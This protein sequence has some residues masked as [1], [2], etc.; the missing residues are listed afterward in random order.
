MKF[1]F[2]VIIFNILIIFFLS[3]VAVLP[4]ALLGRDFAFTFWRS[5]WPLAGVLLIALIVLNVFFLSNR[6]LFRLL[7]REDWP[8]L[9]DYLEHVVLGKRQYSSRK[10][11]LLL[12][13]YLV[14]SDSP[15]VLRL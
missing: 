2:L 12:N 1:K 13:S 6:R 5:G 8:A 9:V 11:R 7:E 4:L 14:M 10:V 15:A 3:A